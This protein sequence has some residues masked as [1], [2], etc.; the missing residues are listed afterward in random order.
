MASGGMRPTAPQNNFGVSATG[1]AGNSGKQPMRIAPGGLYG[2]RTAMVQQQ[3][4]A[5]M[6]SSQPTMQNAQPSAPAPTVP[7][8]PLT[9]LFAPTQRPHEHVTTGALGSGT[10]PVS[11][12]NPIESQYATAYTMFQSMASQPG[13]SPA[14]QY[15][16][17]QIQ[18]GY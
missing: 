9:P 2:Q 16:A 1:G 13:A 17:Q 3:S 11:L 7:Q 8:T 18:Q 6:A 5:P 15:L 4:G 10:A 12:P 14:I